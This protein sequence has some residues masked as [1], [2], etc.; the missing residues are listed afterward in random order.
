M[1]SGPTLIGNPPAA[2]GRRQHVEGHFDLNMSA[3]VE[4]CAHRSLSLSVNVNVSIERRGQT[5][6]L[7]LPRP[8]LAQTESEQLQNSS[9]R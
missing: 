7:L 2:V 9:K 8:G 3:N 4:W 6:S 5:Q 1:L